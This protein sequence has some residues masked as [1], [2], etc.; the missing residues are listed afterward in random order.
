M[1]MIKLV[2]VQWQSCEREKHIWEDLYG[3][4][5]DEIIGRMY[6][7]KA[8]TFVEDRDYRGALGEFEQALTLL[9]K[10]GVQRSYYC[11]ALADKALI[12]CFLGQYKDGLATY[13]QALVLTERDDERDWLL[14]NRGAHLVLAGFYSEQERQA[15]LEQEAAVSHQAR[16]ERETAM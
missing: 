7:L 9:S 4:S 16:E 12:Q 13:E 8:H 14:D 6:L 15:R 1:E 11:N 3:S 2:V 5:W 10:D